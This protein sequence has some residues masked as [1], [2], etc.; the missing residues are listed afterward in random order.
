ML[1]NSTHIEHANS[2]NR[3]RTK[4]LIFDRTKK[5][6][7]LT[8]IGQKSTQAKNIVNEADRI[9]DILN[10]KRDSLRQLLGIIP[11]YANASNVL[12]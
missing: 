2:K 5:P 12:K 8:D 1:C 3:R 4:V 7:Q 9:Q 6:I 11:Y 10:N